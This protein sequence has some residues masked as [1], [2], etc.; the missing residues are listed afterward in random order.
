MHYQ[1]NNFKFK[2]ILI[3]ILI[4]S[5][6][7]KIFLTIIWPQESGDK[8]IYYILAKNLLKGCGLSNSSP[9]LDD[10]VLISGTYFPGFPFLIAVF[11]KFISLDN[12][13]SKN[14]Y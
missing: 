8:E 1:E 7:F 3:S 10:C 2:L 13:L 5:L 4:L 12:F 6:L 11:W 14:D 9:D